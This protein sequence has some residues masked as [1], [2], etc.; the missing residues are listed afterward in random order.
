[1][2]EVGGD[3]RKPYPLG[4]WSSYAGQ[5][6]RKQSAI[7]SE[8]LAA[9]QISIFPLLRMHANCSIIRTPGLAMAHYANQSWATDRICP[10]IRAP[11]LY[12]KYLM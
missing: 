9:G 4:W 7:S 12:P 6:H 5:N 8:V 11:G 3:P 2:S 1:M 10:I